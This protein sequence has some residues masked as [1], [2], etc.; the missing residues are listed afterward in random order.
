MSK[1]SYGE[2]CNYFGIDKV[3]ESIHRREEKFVKRYS[4]YSNSLCH[5]I[6][7]RL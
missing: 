1:D 6:S 3:K 2:M 7:A 4:E 5:S